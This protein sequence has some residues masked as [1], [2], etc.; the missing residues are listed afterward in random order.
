MLNLYKNIKARRLALG[1]SQDELAKKTGY[2]DRTSISKI[3]AGKVDLTQSKIEAFANAL[4]TTTGE[5]MGDTVP[6][7]REKRDAALEEFLDAMHP[8]LKASQELGK[9]PVEIFKSSSG[10]GFFLHFN[11]STSSPEDL[12]E[13]NNAIKKLESITGLRISSAQ[14]QAANDKTVSSES[15][16][17]KGK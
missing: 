6:E 4:E 10:D 3:E 5:L 7:G 8:F 15:D 9:T 16:T 14:K 13:I 2:K 11:F 1:L 12:A 17:K